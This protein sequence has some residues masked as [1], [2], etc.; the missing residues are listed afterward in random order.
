MRAAVFC[1]LDGTWLFSL[2]PFTKVS[3]S[4]SW[5]SST[6]YK[7]RPTFKQVPGFPFPTYSQL[8]R[9]SSQALAVRPGQGLGNS[10][11]ETAAE[12]GPGNEGSSHFGS[13]VD[14]VYTSRV[15]TDPALSF[16]G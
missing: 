4:G 12:A 5:D 14:P 9:K 6:L 8:G 7:Q 15:L 16:W 11:W 2:S 10:L 1:S 3:P 13:Q